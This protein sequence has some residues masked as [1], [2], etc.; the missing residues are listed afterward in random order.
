MAKLGQKK[1]KG[2]SL[3]KV[4]D[5]LFSEL[6]RRR[7]IQRAGGCERCGSQKFDRDNNSGSTLV[8]W[9]QLQCSH[10]IG[11]N[12]RKVRWDP[13]NAYGL[14][15]GCHIYLEHQPVEHAEFAKFRLGD[16]YDLLIASASSRGKVDKELIYLYLKQ[17]LEAI[18][19]TKEVS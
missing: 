12:N 10:V 5:E 4:L 1:L 11:R 14:C 6:I 2:K 19:K 7:A 17:E 13:R 9:K 15:A 3:E 16:E 8:D 18:R